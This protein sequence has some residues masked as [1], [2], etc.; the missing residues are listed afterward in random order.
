MTL[1]LCFVHI[2]SACSFFQSFCLVITSLSSCNLQDAMELSESIE[3]AMF[4][5]EQQEGYEVER[6]MD[7]ETTDY[8][9]TGANNQ[10][11]PTTPARL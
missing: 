9:G 2:L 1:N 11:D 6:R 5:M 3:E 10:H 4:G 7:I 8:P